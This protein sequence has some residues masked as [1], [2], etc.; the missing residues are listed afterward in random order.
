MLAREHRLTSSGDI[1]TVIRSGKRSSNKF[2][3][4]HYLPAD[5]HQFAIVT[6]RAVGNA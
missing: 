4:L 6:S 2:V 5:T 3:T 1:R